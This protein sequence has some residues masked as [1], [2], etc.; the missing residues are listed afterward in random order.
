MILLFFKDKKMKT[1][2]F[3][4]MAAAALILAGCANDENGID[5]GAVKLRLTSGVEVQQ[6]RAFTPT[7]STSITAGEVVSVWVD[8]AGTIP[9]PTPIYEANQLTATDG[10]GFSGSD[11]FFPETGNNVN[12]YAVHGNFTA[13]FTG[14]A[15]F[16]TAAVEYSVA[17][18]QSKGGTAYTNSDLLY[19]YEKGVAR[20][21]SPVQLTFYHMLSKLELAIVKGEGAPELAQSNAVKLG[22]VTLNGN[23]TPSTSADMSIQSQRAGML[24]AASKTSSGDMTLGQTTCTDFTD[25]N[26]KYN[27]AI[28]VPQEMK[29]KVLTFTLADGG[30]LKYTI[31]AFST[32]PGAA[33]FESGKKYQ[34]Q[35]TLKLTGLEVTSKIE[36][37]DAVGID[38]V[39]GDAVMD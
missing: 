33:V 30:T 11:M 14:G 6:T 27:E 4:T 39:P 31:P 15:A 1:N 24:S 10:N 7:Q 17:A 32:T 20:S 21:N 38:P 18:D 25:P 29:D 34:Y 2:L 5:N 26:V 9:D 35:I 36:D 23:F 12:I 8:D 37:W 28:L 13:P 19:A 16:P 22:G 3:V